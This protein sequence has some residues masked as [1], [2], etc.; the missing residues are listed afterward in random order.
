MYCCEVFFFSP[1]YTYGFKKGCRVESK[2]T[3]VTH[4]PPRL[5]LHQYHLNVKSVLRSEFKPLGNLHYY[6]KVIFVV[7][8]VG[9]TGLQTRKSTV[10]LFM[11]AIPLNQAE[12]SGLGVIGIGHSSYI[13]RF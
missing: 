11:V 10:M 6:T 2:N 5:H 7:V 9:V 13:F 1:L 3:C 8:E 12:I 4:L